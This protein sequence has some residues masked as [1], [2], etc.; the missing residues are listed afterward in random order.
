MELPRFNENSHLEQQSLFP[1]LDAF[2]VKET[3]GSV[4]VS[5]KDGRMDIQCAK[6]SRRLYGRGVLVDNSYF[7][8]GTIC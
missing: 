2:F 1:S 7:V 4:D 3:I 8:L 5:C 6:D